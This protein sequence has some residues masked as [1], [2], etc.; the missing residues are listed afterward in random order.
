MGVIMKLN[1]KQVVQLDAQQ[2]YNILEK[3]INRLLNTSVYFDVTSN[4]YKKMALN[5]IEETKTT[6]KETMLYDRYVEKEISKF[7]KAKTK[8]YLHSSQGIWVIINFINK[9]FKPMITLDDAKYNYKRL[10]NFLEKYNYKMSYNTYEKLINENELFLKM[11]NMLDCRELL[12][13]GNSEN[14]KINKTEPKVKLEQKTSEDELLLDD[15]LKMYLNELKDISVLT[16]EE[17][18][19]L[20]TK[21]LQGDIFARNELI[22][23]NLK[24]VVMFAK[25]YVDDKNELEDLIQ[26]GNLGLMKAI[27][28][29][30]PNKGFKL[31]TY[32]ALWI[33]QNI[34]RYKVNNNI[35]RVSLHSDGL[36]KKY[37]MAVEKLE[38]EL[39]RYP[40][41]KEIA[42][43]MNLKEEQIRRLEIVQK[44]IVSLNLKIDSD[45]EIEM[46]ELISSNELTPE[47]ELINKVDNSIIREILNNKDLNDREKLVIALRC[48]FKCNKPLNLNEISVIL[49]VSSE[50]VRQIFNL[51]IAKLR[52]DTLVRELR[53]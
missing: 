32:A 22:R 4:E 46:E 28:K 51:G 25:K 13:I 44:D 18:I 49:N 16:E 10:A 33:K 39:G 30:D 8:Q 27:E 17:E 7:I 38:M 6:Y 3:K 34:T 23:H 15:S 19:E 35:Y 1:V 43:E 31:S 14:N 45:G 20:V 11:T 40:T 2:I 5:V 47:T 48:G 50:R 41:K 24:L 21:A 9:C 53:R 52:K 26:V 37:K 29:F 36:L 42:D 12:S